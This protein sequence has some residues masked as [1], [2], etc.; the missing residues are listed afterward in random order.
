MKRLASII[1]IFSFALGTLI[2]FSRIRDFTQYKLDPKSDRVYSYQ[3]NINLANQKEFVNLPGIGPSLA[4]EII[5]YREKRGGFKSVE[6]L[7]RVK[8]IGKKKFLAIKPYLTLEI[9]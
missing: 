1:F 3:L 2:Y 9:Y 7:L 8:G 5:N 4:A 6:D